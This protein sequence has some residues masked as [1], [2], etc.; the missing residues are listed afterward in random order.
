MGIDNESKINKNSET[1]YSFYELPEGD[2]EDNWIQFN[3]NLMKVKDFRILNSVIN[4]CIFELDK[5]NISQARKD[6]IQRVMAAAMSKL[7]EMEDNLEDPSLKDIE[8]KT[9]HNV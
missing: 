1:V 4:L 5:E 9:T 7:Q 3:M 2:R 8:K 6:W